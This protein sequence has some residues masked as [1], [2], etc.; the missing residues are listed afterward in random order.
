[1]V[2]IDVSMNILLFLYNIDDV[3]TMSVGQNNN[4]V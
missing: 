3:S 2:Y 1:M 4:D